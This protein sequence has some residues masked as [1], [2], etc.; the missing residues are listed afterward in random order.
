MPQIDISQLPQ[1]EVKIVFT[2]SMEEAKPYLDEA[3]RDLSAHRPIP[4][5]RPGKAGYPEVKA[6]FGEMAI[7]ETALERIV[8]AFY[9]K[10]VMSEG[11][12]TVGS[13]SVN[14]DQLTPG[15]DIKFTVIAPVEPKVES[16]ADFSKCK[17]EKK[18]T[19]IGEKEVD[20]VVDQLRKMRREEV[21][22]ERASTVD[23]LV[24]IDL[25][26]QKDKVPV[27]GGSGSGY[28]V[29][30]N[31]NHYIPGFTKELIGIKAGEER[32]FT[33]PFPAEHYQKNL[34]GQNVDFTAKA[35]EVYELKMPEVNEEF[36]KKA[37]FDTVEK[38]REQ[39]KGN[40]E[41]EATQK[42]NEAAEIALL[43]KLVDASKFSEVPQVLVNEEVRRMISEL[44]SGVEQQGGNWDEYLKS[45]NKTLDDMRLDF[46]PQAVRRIKTA[47]LIKAIANQ[48]KIEVTEEDV[49]KE[50]DRILEQVRPEDKE[51]RERVVS[52]EYREYVQIQ[53]RNRKALEWVKAKC[54]A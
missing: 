15:Q 36:S 37:G 46:A 32:T 4:G 40:L 27:E 51:T 30:L 35:T 49:D 12:N 42:N 14:V 50:I 28:R 52:A 16:M 19:K 23:D 8:R 39:L 3:V 2:V 38:L 17:V 44:Q 18:D 6:A 11:L 13:P 20:E 5:F 45:I 21:K 9:V 29:Y 31:E 41:A 7:Y 10:T 25:S 24:I 43:E 22:V 54:I 48:E 47:V 34:A 33:L 53:M 26:I 1:S